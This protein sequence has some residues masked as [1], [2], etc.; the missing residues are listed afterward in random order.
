SRRSTSLVLA[1]PTSSWPCR[2]LGSTSRPWPISMTW[3]TLFMGAIIGGCAS[4]PST[5]I[6]R[7]ISSA[8][9]ALATIASSKASA[10]PR[11]GPAAG[12]AEVIVDITTTGATLA[13]NHLK[14][15]D[16]GLV[17]ESQAVLA[18]SLRADWSDAA[19]RAVSGLLGR[20]AARQLGKTSYIIRVRIEKAA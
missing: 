15:L 14:V 10:R 19:V 8:A 18:A 5:S 2:G 4:R 6:W 9:T 11:A 12:P 13:A 20:L 7:A 3:R 17:L 16:D 1:A